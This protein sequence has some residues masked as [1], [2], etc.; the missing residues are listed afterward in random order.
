MFC[1]AMSFIGCGHKH[2]EASTIITTQNDSVVGDSM[3]YGLA[4]EGS[5]DSVLIVYPTS[6]D[7]PVKFNIIDAKEDGK[8][9][10]KI[11]VGD[12]IGVVVDPKDKTT[13]L[14]V[15]NLDLIKATWTYPV[16]PTFKEL[17]HL[18]PR[19]QKRMESMA[20]Q[21]IPDSMKA[22]YLVPREYG[23]TLKRNHKAQAVGRIFAAGADDADSPVEYPEVKNY[24][25]WY[26]WNGHVILVSGGK[27]IMNNKVIDE[28]PL[29]YDTLNFVSLDDDSL[30]V[31]IRGVRYGFHR[32]TNA[33]EANSEA[34]EKAKKVAEIKT[35]ETKR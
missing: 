18:S 24:H 19:M 25:S 31:K 8:I 1:V 4:C 29:V 14:M 20:L 7:D 10:G 23:F 12:W 11:T 17:S 32:M 30:I 6:G 35:E 9:I 33:I 13:A 28:K 27:T 26:P 34:T 16:M 5:T 21:E 3:F 22:L 2:P 15:I